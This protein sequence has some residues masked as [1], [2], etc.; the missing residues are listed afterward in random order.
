M[1]IQK[2]WGKPQLYTFH[3]FCLASDTAGATS[4]GCVRP[5]CL[6]M[7]HPFQP[8]EA[9]S[10]PS[11]TAVAFPYPGAAVEPQLGLPSRDFPS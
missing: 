7:K 3:E 9:N 4:T 6:L 11:A 8:T 1:D 10:D 2:N 5:S